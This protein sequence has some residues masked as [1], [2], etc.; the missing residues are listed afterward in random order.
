METV[1]NF[2][3]GGQAQADSTMLVGAIFFTF[4][5]MFFF[6]LAVTDMVQRRSDIRKRA[7]IDRSLDTSSFAPERDWETNARSLRFKSFAENTARLA[8]VER[9]RRSEKRESEESKLQ[10]SLVGAGFFGANSALWFQAVRFALLLGLPFILHLTLN[11]FEFEM[12]ASS[13]VGL[14]AAAGGIGFLLPGRYLA[15][16]QKKMRMECRDG[17][18]DF[19]DLLVICAEAG[20][21]P[22][23]A[24]DRI[25]REISNSYP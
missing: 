20:L 14:L 11:Y 5:F 9:G 17:F 1:L 8:T 22:R 7:S 21:G 12:Q 13:R 25:S 15:Q 2:V 16:R 6:V 10:R 4:M 24:I 23:A 3:S 18:P 19:M